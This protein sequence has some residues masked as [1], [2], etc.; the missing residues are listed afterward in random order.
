MATYDKE[1]LMDVDIERMTGSGVIDALN[2][3]RDEF[4]EDRVKMINYM[5]GNCSIAHDEGR[6]GYVETVVRD[7]MR[8]V[9]PVLQRVFTTAR[10]IVEFIP[11]SE[12]KSKVA[13]QMTAYCHYA[14]NRCKG[15]LHTDSAIKDAL[16]HKKGFVKVYWD[17][18]RTEET[19]RLEARTEEQVTLLLQEPGVELMDSRQYMSPE[20]ITLYDLVITMTEVTG[21]IGMK[22][23][24]TERFF[25]DS[26]ATSMDD[27]RV[28][29]HTEDKTVSEL[30]GMGFD[31]E[32]LCGLIGRDDQYTNEERYA[33]D[34]YDQHRYDESASG[35]KSEQ[36]V[37]VAETYIYLDVEGTGSSKLCK[38]L[39]AGRQYSHMLGWELWDM[40]LIA[41]FDA[42]PVPH[43]FFGRSLAEMLISDQDINTVLIRGV[44]DNAAMV[45]N[46]RMVVNTGMV[47]D[48]RQITNNEIGAVLPVRGDPR[49]AVYYDATPFMG[50]EL[51]PF[52]DKMQRMSEEK[53]GVMEQ[54]SSLS[55][56]LLQSTTPTAIIAKM[57]AQEGQTEYL[58]RNLAETG[59]TDLFRFIAKLVA[60]NVDAPTMARISGTWQ[61]VDPRTWDLDMDMDV[62]VGLGSGK[63]EERLQGLMATKETQEAI[64]SNY[65][66]DNPLVSLTQYRQTLVDILEI[67]GLRDPDKYIKPLNEEMEQQYLQQQ[68]EAAANAPP[69]PNPLADV[70]MVKMMSK[71]QE[72][73]YKS[74]MDMILHRMKE[75][76]ERDEMDQD[77]ILKLTNMLLDAGV[78]HEKIKATGAPVEK[79][80]QQAKSKPR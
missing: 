31:Y 14:F 57:Q 70:E 25:I 8:R 40:P 37:Q 66:P 13:A 50:G 72:L 55:P 26:H 78:E 17:E 29:G 41:C 73:E 47:Q 18:S 76:I 42:E 6:S 36:I 10:K 53:T 27:F 28:M 11:T 1:P 19:L 23:F 79:A 54:T 34:G 45:N 74:Q 77:A 52:L 5:K 24:P 15:F 68:A 64:I 4:Q 35:T 38:V 32:T 51:L 30:V 62:N 61:E 3:M 80:I 9:I 65:G 58:A 59:F 49:Q 33:R 71:M 69:P 39:M 48:T 2:Y 7:A 43:R 16:E 63:T 56:D 75:D 44:L 67:Q 21:D 22:S 12:E 46:P 20:G 60:E